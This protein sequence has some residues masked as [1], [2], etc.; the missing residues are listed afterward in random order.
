MAVKQKPGLIVSLSQDRSLMLSLGGVVV[1]LI[2]TMVI[3]EHFGGSAK[4]AELVARAGVWAPV[5]F[6]LAKAMTYVVAPLSGGPVKIIAGTLFGFIPG[7]IYSTLGDLLGASINFWIARLFGQ[8]AM[9]KLLSKKSY[10]KV[11]GFVAHIETWKTLLAARIILSSFYD[12]IS[13]T[14]GLS[15]LRYKTFF[16]VTLLGGIPGSMIAVGLGAS[17][18]AN[19]KLFIGLVIGGML[20]FLISSWAS[21]K[22]KE[23]EKTKS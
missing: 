7:V 18:F 3:I 16:W 14:A 12:F 13:Y 10:Q 21:E 22:L 8:K 9:R 4:L 1:I 6:I 15:K 17:L 20:L 23:D 5:V 11:D 2:I 19:T